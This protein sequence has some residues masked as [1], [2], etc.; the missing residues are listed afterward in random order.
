[1]ARSR[2][3]LILFRDGRTLVAMGD[4][5]VQVIHEK[6][7]EKIWAMLIDANDGMVIPEGV[8]KRR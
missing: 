7:E 4:G 5:S 3:S 2:S 6:H 8:F 1:M